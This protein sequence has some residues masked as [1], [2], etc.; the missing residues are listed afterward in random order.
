MKKARNYSAYAIGQLDKG[1][2]FHV[3]KVCWGRL[4]ARAEKRTGEVI[5][6]C[7]IHVADK[8]S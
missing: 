6:K 5:R 1:K 7:E 4:M 3:R 2:Q 8:A